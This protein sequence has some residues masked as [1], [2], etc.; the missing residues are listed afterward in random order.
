M[1]RLVYRSASGTAGSLTPRPGKDTEGPKR[2]LSSF[3][4]AAAAPK[5]SRLQVIDLDLLPPHLCGI[6]DGDGHV[7]IAPVRPDGTIDDERLREWASQRQAGPR[8]AFT[9]AIL[10]AIVDVKE[11]ND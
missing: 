9:D 3:T 10:R 1:A 5:S 6:A 2:G 4:T 11:P 8:H 7:S